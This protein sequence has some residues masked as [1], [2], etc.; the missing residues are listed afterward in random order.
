MRIRK[1]EFIFLSW[2]DRGIVLA[3]GLNSPNDSDHSE[4][5]GVLEW[6]D[7]F[8]DWGL[9]CVH[10]LSWFLARVTL[11]FEHEWEVGCWFEWV[12]PNFVVISEWVH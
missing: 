11:L 3:S 10:F 8:Q 2:V 7:S 12:V 6:V 5:V 4:K 1:S 9:K